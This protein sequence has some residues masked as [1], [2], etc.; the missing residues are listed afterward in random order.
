[1]ARRKMRKQFL[2]ATDQLDKPVLAL[3]SIL[4]WFLNCD[5]VWKQCGELSDWEDN[6]NSRADLE[7]GLPK[8]L[9]RMI[10]LTWEGSRIVR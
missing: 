2:E 9:A 4:Q 7:A 5:C 8:D 3:N 1:M 6:V 10:A